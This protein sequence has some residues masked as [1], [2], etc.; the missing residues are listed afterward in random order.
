MDTMAAIRETFFQECEEQL[1][2]LEVGLNAM[3]EGVADSETVN[4]VF[5]AVHSIKGGAGAFKLDRLVRFAHTF[6]T[7]LDLIRSG[8]LAPSQTVVRTMLRSADLLADLVK[9][10]RSDHPVDEARVDAQIAEL[11]ALSEPVKS[12]A[13]S[14]VR[15]RRWRRSRLPA[16]AARARRLRRRRRDHRRRRYV[17]K[18]IPAPDLYR[19]GNETVRL[20]RELSR[21]GEIPRRMRHAGH[22][23]TARR[24]RPRRR[25]SRLARRT[26]DDR[27]RGVDP[28]VVRIR[29]RRL[30]ARDRRRARRRVAQ[31]DA[32]PP[33]APIEFA[34]AR[35]VVAEV[36][37]EPLRRRAGGRPIEPAAAAP[38]VEPDKAEGRRR[39]AGSG[40][41]GGDDPRRSRARRSPDQSGR[42]AGD[43]PGDAVAARAGGRAGALVERRRRPRRARAIDPRDP[44]RRDGDP[45]PAGQAAVPAHV[46]HRARADR[47]DRQGRCGCAPKAKRPRSTAR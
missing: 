37:G 10:S 43:Q 46:A 5:R 12:A 8:Q 26:D 44:G 40:G 14:S 1:G 3:D 36:L 27:R 34:A 41:D 22:V 2:E 23:P 18:F 9:A 33:T 32:A 47:R 25:L 11:K 17:I 16:G 4:A 20:L 31:I 13:E 30:R 45:R 24:A 21:M 42:R 35:R 39:Q 15:R 29:R 7:S 28:R 6:E 19:K 38:A